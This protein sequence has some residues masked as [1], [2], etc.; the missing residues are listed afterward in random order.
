MRF[1]ILWLLLAAWKISSSTAIQNC[2]VA[3]NDFSYILHGV[4]NGTGELKTILCVLRFFMINKL[5]NF[6]I[7]LCKIDHYRVQ[8]ISENHAVF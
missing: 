8:I 1:E 4:D 3:N 6:Q 2:F 5:L 7:I